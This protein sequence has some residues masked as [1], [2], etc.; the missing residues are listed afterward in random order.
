MDHLGGSFDLDQ[1]LGQ[2]QTIQTGLSLA[3]MSGAGWPSVALL[4]CLVV[5][6]LS[7]PAM[8]GGEDGT[9]FHGY[10]SPVSQPGL[11]TVQSQEATIVHGSLK[12]LLR[13]KLRTG[14][15][16]LQSPSVGLS[17]SQDQPIFKKQ[18]N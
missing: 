16:A 17:K 13:P 7:A 11:L 2:F 8:V 6:W 15:W 10:H 4:T 3:L 5:G 18:E 14:T 9:G 1:T 12:G